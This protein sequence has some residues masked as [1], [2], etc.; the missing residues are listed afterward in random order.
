MKII[1]FGLARQMHSS[2]TPPLYRKEST[3]T[4][5]F[6]ESQGSIVERQLTQHVVTRWY[7][8]PELILMQDHYTG[9]IDIWSV[10]C[11]LVGEGKKTEAKAELLQTLEPDVTRVRPLFPGTT[12]FP[13]SAP[14]K[15]KTK[16]IKIEQEF[17][18][19]T[20]QLEKIFEITGTPSLADIEEMDEGP[21]KEVWNVQGTER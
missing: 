10:G 19:E 1:D 14:K 17:R 4:S 15:D 6:W 18:A 9:A 7:R 2:S 21:M 5:S 11:I 12:C 3:D 16:Y 8:A 13:L 20:H